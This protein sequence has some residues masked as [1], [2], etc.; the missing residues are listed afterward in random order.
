MMRA[1]N[2]VLPHGWVVVDVSRRE[3]AVFHEKYF[4]TQKDDAQGYNSN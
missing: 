1:F 2:I 4:Y 3:L